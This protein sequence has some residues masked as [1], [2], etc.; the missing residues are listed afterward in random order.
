MG[1]AESSH[2]SATVENLANGVQKLQITSA[3][4]T[5]SGTVQQV[6]DQVLGQLKLEEDEIK[7]TNEK[8]DI[9]VR[10]FNFSS[11]QFRRYFFVLLFQVK[12]KMIEGLKEQSGLFKMLFKEIAWTGSYYEGLKISNPDEFD[13]N[14]VLRMPV[15]DNQINVSI[16]CLHFFS[17]LKTAV[18]FLN[19]CCFFFFVRLNQD[20]ICLDM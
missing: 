15:K 10:S 7:K 11:A 8:L 3:S 18:I 13:L 2:A 6:L 9:L 20:L 4:S 19:N 14:I 5:Y 16:F 17:N 1:A 12:R